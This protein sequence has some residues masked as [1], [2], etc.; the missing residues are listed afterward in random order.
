MTAYSGGL[1]LRQQASGLLPEPLNLPPI[2]LHLFVRFRHRSNALAEGRRDF[3]LYVGLGFSSFEQ[4]V[5]ERRVE[6]QAI[7][8]VEEAAVA[9]QNLRGVLR[10]RAALQSALRQIADDAQHVHHGGERERRA[11]RQLAEE[12]EVRERG[13]QKARGHA[14]H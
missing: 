14:A 7:E 9:G 1:Q 3:L 8:T 6:E 11:E 10:L 12:P 4:I 2:T 5:Y 13:Q